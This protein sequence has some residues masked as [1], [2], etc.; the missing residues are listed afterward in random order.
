VDRL[1]ISLLLVFLMWG[2]SIPTRPRAVGGGVRAPTGAYAALR[3]VT[4]KDGV[5]ASGYPLGPMPLF[6]LEM[7]HAGA[8][9]F[10]VVRIIAASDGIVQ[11]V[12]IVRS[13]QREFE[14]ST[15]AA[16]QKWRVRRVVD[17]PAGEIVLECNIVFSFE[18]LDEFRKKNA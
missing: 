15:L 3:E 17:A 2:C 12:E 4:G 10:V 8:E 7:K 14:A 5:A 1:V 16:A 6:P 11:S 18:E 13:S 9:G